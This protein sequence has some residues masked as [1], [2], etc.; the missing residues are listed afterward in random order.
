MRIGIDGIPLHYLK[1]GVGHYT[2]EVARCL[3]LASPP[4]EFELISPHPFVSQPGDGDDTEAPPNLRAVQVET[5]LLERRWWTIGLPRYIKRHPLALFHG[6]NFEV[7]LWKRCPTVLTIHDLSVL[8]YPETHQRRFVYR[9][10]LML[11]LMSRSATMIVTPSESVRREVCQHLR[12][13]PEK[14]VAVPEAARRIF[15]QMPPAQAA[16]VRERLGVE[17]RFLLYVGTIEPRKNLIALVRAFVEILRTTTLRPQLVI[18]GKKG[19]LSDDLYAYIKASE[20]AD[21]ILFTGYVTD[22]ELR[23]LYSSCSAFVYPSMYEGF[24]LPPLEA[25]A[26]GAPVIASDIGSIREAVGDAARLVDPKDVNA[27][28]RRIVN[29]LEDDGERRHLS[30]AGLKHAARFSWERTASSIQEVYDEAL[31]RAGPA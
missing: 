30:A 24:G 25:M 5:N 2:F 29:L 6:T 12:A 21:R 26:C 31:R 20:T 15:R 16:T 9:T 11:P 28:A 1:T 10:R 17:D 23:A 8:L 3:A 19:W 4:D 14:V 18:A 13:A 27:L 7:P 22:D